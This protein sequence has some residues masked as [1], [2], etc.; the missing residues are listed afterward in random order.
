MASRELDA[1]A[2]HALAQA[3]VEDRHVVDRLG[4]DHEHGVRELEV[5]DRRLQRRLGERAVQLERQ[6]ARA[7]E[8]RCG[9]RGPRAAGARAGSPPRWSPRRR[10]ARRC[11][12]RARR[13]AGGGLLQ[14]AL[15][16]DR[17]QLAAVA[18][19]RLGVHALVDVGATGRRSGP[20]RRA[21]RRRPRLCSRASTRSDALVAHGELTLHCAGHSVQTE[22]A[23]SM[24]HG[25]A[26][27]R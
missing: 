13:E 6:C 16:G 7:R 10:R 27:K 11:C 15:P 22:P 3:Q 5:G 12:S 14:R 1:V 23:S 17:A 2:A 8:S 9:S 20:Y 25:R 18:H 19:Q 26:R 4:V 21:S 24:S